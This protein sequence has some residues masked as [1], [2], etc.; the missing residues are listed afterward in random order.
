[1]FELENDFADHEYE[2]DLSNP[3]PK[4]LKKEGLNLK[5]KNCT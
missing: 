3:L 2:V 1:M 4:K 5:R